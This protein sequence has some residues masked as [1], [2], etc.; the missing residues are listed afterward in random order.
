MRP[1]TKKSAAREGFEWGREWGAWAFK[2]VLSKAPP[3]CSRARRERYAVGVEILLEGQRNQIAEDHG[4]IIA[5]AWAQAARRVINRRVGATTL[6]RRSPSPPAAAAEPYKG[7]SDR[8]GRG[9]KC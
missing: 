3:D 8:R 4:E 7:T 9:A 1:L 2:R 6:A 5:D